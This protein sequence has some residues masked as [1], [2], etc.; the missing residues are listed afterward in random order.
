MLYVGQIIID[1]QYANMSLAGGVHPFQCVQFTQ[2]KKV[3]QNCPTKTAVLIS[4]P[5]KKK[6]GEIVFPSTFGG[7]DMVGICIGGI[8]KVKKGF[9]SQK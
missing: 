6:R 7:E 9:P 2:T 1:N 4:P 3:Q 8:M 5:S